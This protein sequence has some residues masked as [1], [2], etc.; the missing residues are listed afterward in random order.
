MQHIQTIFEDLGGHFVTPAPK[1][2]EKVARVK[3]V[4]FDWDGV[5]ND[6]V[7]TESGQNH[8]CTSFP[9]RVYGVRSQ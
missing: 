6:G 3:A 5:F 8:G 2:A 7:K 9:G 1:L 4:V